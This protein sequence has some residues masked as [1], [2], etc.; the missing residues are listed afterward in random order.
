MESGSVVILVNETIPPGAIAL[1]GKGLG[2]IPTP[3]VDV[4]EARLDMRLV[5]NKILYHSH[6]HLGNPHCSPEGYKMP[7]KYRRKNYMKAKPSSKIWQR[8]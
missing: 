6:N 8:T 4:Q 7:A 2:F 1:L 5:T 3:N